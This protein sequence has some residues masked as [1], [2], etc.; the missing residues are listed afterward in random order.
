MGAHVSCASP[1]GWGTW[2]GAQTTHSSRRRSIFVSWLWVAVQEM[3]FLAGKHLCLSCPFYPLSCLVSSSFFKGNYSFCSRRFGCVH[4]RWWVQ[5]LPMFLS[6]NW[7]NSIQVSCSVMLDS[8]WLHGLQHARLSCPSPTPGACSNSCPLSWWS[9]PIISSS[10]VPF[11]SC[12]QSLPASGT[13]LMSQ[14][15][16]SGG[17][18]LRASASAS[19]LP[20]NIQDWF[21]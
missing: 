15:F 8:L 17:Q 3:D 2:Y 16:E 18:S 7:T 12:L 9:H 4:V 14:F 1:K 13:F 11:S 21:Y 20:M 6:L 5:D 10:V 19:V